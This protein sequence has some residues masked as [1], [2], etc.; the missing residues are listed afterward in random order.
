MVLSPYLKFE[1]G[2]INGKNPRSSV[3]VQAIHASPSH[4]GNVYGQ[5]K[6]AD[7]SVVPVQK[8]ALAI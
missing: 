3:P 7:D 6:G 2:R 5:V 1:F 8:Y 4:S